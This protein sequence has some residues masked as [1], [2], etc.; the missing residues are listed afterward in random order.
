MKAKL[1]KIL[2]RDDYLC[3]IHVGGCGK[4]IDCEKDEPTIDHIW[5][6][7]Y[8]KNH[9][10]KSMFQ[11]Q[12]N[13]QPMCRECNNKKGGQMIN[14]P[15]FQ[16]TCHHIYITDK[17]GLLCFYIENDCWKSVEITNVGIVEPSAERL[18]PPT[19]ITV[20][21]Q[22]EKQGF[23]IGGFGHLMSGYY[24]FG[25][26]MANARQLFEVER[27][28]KCMVECEEFRRHYEEDD[29]E[30]LKAEF[31]E[32]TENAVAKFYFLRILLNLRK[33]HGVRY[34]SVFANDFDLRKAILTRELKKEILSIDENN[35][36]AIFTILVSY[37]QRHIEHLLNIG[38]L[39]WKHLRSA[40]D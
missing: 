24:P 4:K 2:E 36:E 14:P 13:C 27:F 37:F 38:D 40:S 12:W 35:F 39:K 25:R 20:G 33:E 23:E 30:S 22:Y 5:S 21:R 16:C 6:K 10:N 19:K 9:E 15:K 34:M 1:R 3:G 29:G 7:S 32:K 31:G 26:I 18:V 11:K 17:G 8:S 28:H